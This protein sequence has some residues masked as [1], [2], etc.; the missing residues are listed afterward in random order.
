MSAP[1]RGRRPATDQIVD[2]SMISSRGQGRQDRRE[3]PRQ[4]GLARARRPDQQHVVRPGGADLERALG[5]GLA[6]HVGE[7]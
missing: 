2:A 5:V 3:A 6:A 4:H 7:V 1:E